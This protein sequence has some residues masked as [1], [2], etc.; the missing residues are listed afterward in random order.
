MHFSE[1]TRWGQIRCCFSGVSCSRPT[2]GPPLLGC[3]TDGGTNIE[4]WF[5][6]SP[7]SSSPYCTKG[8][9]RYLDFFYRRKWILINDPL[10]WNKRSGWGLKVIE[11]SSWRTG[12]RRLWPQKQVRLPPGFCTAHEIM[13]F[14][15]LNGGGKEYFVTCKM[16]MKF[17][18]IVVHE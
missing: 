1:K 4:V 10:P 14:M 7:S 16:Y 18:Y 8:C 17:K 13:E 2:S 6:L 11:I 12:F 9:I 3:E 5:P 15:S